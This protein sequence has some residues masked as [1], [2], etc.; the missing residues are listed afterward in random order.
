MGNYASIFSL[1]KFLEEHSDPYFLVNIGVCGYWGEKYPCI[2][3]SV[4]H[5]IQIQK[6]QIIPQNFLFVPLKHLISSEV[7]VKNEAEIRYFIDTLGENSVFVDMESVGIE[8]VAQQFQYPRLFLKVPCDQIGK[9]TE[10]FD[11]TQA[12]LFLRKNL[13][14]GQLVQQLLI[15]LQ[16]NEKSDS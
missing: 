10:S 9:E 1:T 14:Y 8:Y 11:Y 5:Q 16:K 3:A 12:L 6:E 2:Q 7:P 13:D 15:F 4:L